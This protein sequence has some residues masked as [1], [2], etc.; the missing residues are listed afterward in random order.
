LYIAI[1]KFTKWPEATPVV[2]INKQSAVNFIK[3]IICRFGVPK[4]IITDNGTHFTSN[5]FQDYCE[6]LVI[7]VCYALVAHPKTNGQ[8]EHANTEILK[9]LKTHTYDA[10]TKHGANWIDDLPCVLWANRTTAS[11]ATGETPFFLVY[12]AEAVLTPEVSMGSPRAQMYDEDMQDQARLRD[13]D[14]IEEGRRQAS[15]RNAKY[16]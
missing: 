16:Q 10:L 12:G 3:S 2:T 8:A 9:G 5:V 1:N 14:L 15:I 7:T 11:R 6:D 4:C 13:V